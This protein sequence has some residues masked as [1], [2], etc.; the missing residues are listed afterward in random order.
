MIDRTN[1][2]GKEAG[3]GEGVPQVMSDAAETVR[4]HLV[5]LRGGAPFLSPTDAS[6]LLQWLE[7]GVSTA[8]IL[9]G[10]DRAATVRQARRTRGPLTLRHAKRYLKNFPSVGASGTPSAPVAATPDH[11]LLDLLCDMPAH[12]DAQAHHEL[13][14]ALTDLSLDHPDQAATEALSAVSQFFVSTWE[15]LSDEERGAYEG[16]ALQQLG[17]L[18][19]LLGDADLQEMIEA[20]ARGLLRQRYPSLSSENI[21][22]RIQP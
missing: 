5:A 9:W 18:A 22:R 16:E 20:H 19:T 6:L 4:G 2:S 10:L 1:M 11:P 21:L 14:D 3:V 7:Q 15:R 12:H 17:D 13:R 8:A